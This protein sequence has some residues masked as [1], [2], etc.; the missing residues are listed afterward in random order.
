MAT[1]RLNFT[2]P[3]TA[4]AQTS[5][6]V[7]YRVAGT[8]GPYTE[9]GGQL[10]SPINIDVVDLTSYEGYIKTN[11]GNGN[12]STQI[13]FT[14]PYVPVVLETPCVKLEEMIGIT[15]SRG[16][17]LGQ[18]YDY[19]R[20]ALVASLEAPH[21][22]D[23]TVL[24][25]FIEYN[26]TGSREFQV[27]LV[28]AAGELTA[29]YEYST[30]NPV[31]PGNDSVCRDE[32][33]HFQGTSTQTPSCGATGGGGGNGTLTETAYR[34]NATRYDT[35]ELA[36]QNPSSA[37]D[38]TQILYRLDR[39]DGQANFEPFYL[40]A[41]GTE[42]LSEGYYHYIIDGQPASAVLYVYSDA[43][44]ILLDTYNPCT[45]LVNNLYLWSARPSIEMACA[46][47]APNSGNGFQAY[48]SN[49]DL[50]VGQEVFFIDPS[51]S[52]FTTLPSTFHKR[53]D[54][55]I[56]VIDA[57]G[58]VE[59]IARTCVGVNDPDPYAPALKVRAAVQTPE[60]TCSMEYNPED[61]IQIYAAN[62]GSATAIGDIIYLD[63]LGE[64]PVPAGFYRS[65]DLS[66]GG[67]PPSTT[68]TNF[69]VGAGGEVLAINLCQ[70]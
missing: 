60:E 41:Q 55:D 26:T 67:F 38:L 3:A 63:S 20:S 50:V 8:T 59:A 17:C 4:N 28:I 1:L 36:C 39:Q 9:K 24:A 61:G 11:C 5:Y 34:I 30:K 15:Q 64:Q 18:E 14:A 42:Q 44:G 51:T 46:D 69:E 53:Q 57:D 47:T 65:G 32:S 54:G 21:D 2:P 10:V 7:F 29:R 43:N 13:D 52:T 70:Q 16:M 66:T 27:P 48:T 49:G 6:S 33:Q 31:D 37:G 19:E 56:L 35:R 68:P 40:D 23:I 62:N 45:F 12:Y 25:D 58:R 22:Q